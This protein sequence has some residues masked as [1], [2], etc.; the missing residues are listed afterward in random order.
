MYDQKPVFANHEFLL[1]FVVQDKVELEASKI[2]AAKQEAEKREK[3]EK[4]K[5]EREESRKK[6]FEL[7]R[8]E[9]ERKQQKKK[10]TE[11]G[12]RADPTVNIYNILNPAFSQPG[13]TSAVPPSSPAPKPNPPPS[14]Q[15]QPL[16]FSTAGPP[17]PA[18]LINSQLGSSP[19]ICFL[20][21]LRPIFVPIGGF[22]FLTSCGSGLILI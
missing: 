21:N 13:C 17:A 11:Q 8:I 19:L 18:N 3:A 16:I 14:V 9:Q 4:L 1:I 7:Q 12:T 10:L 22:L 6:Q 2:E 15:Q 5:R 20:V